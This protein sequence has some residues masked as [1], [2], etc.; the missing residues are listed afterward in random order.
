MHETEGK[1]QVRT[2]AS[3][4][5]DR[6]IERLSARLSPEIISDHIGDQYLKT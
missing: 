6:N 3:D 5:S 4:E 1:F 2:A